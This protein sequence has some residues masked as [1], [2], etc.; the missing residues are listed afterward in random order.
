VE[1]M[2][3]LERAY[4]VPEQGKPGNA[5]LSLN[6]D[7][8]HRAFENVTSVQNSEKGEGSRFIN[9]VVERDPQRLKFFRKHLKMVNDLY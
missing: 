4:T 1:D 6:P 9:L 5:R 7:F 2:S 8:M 3:K